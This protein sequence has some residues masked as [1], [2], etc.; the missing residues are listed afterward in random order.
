MKLLHNFSSGFDLAHKSHFGCDHSVRS[1]A[2]FPLTPAL[3]PRERENRLP[4]FGKTNKVG[5]GAKLESVLSEG[6]GDLQLSAVCR[7]ARLRA[8][9][10]IF[11]HA[12]T[13]IRQRM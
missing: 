3:S 9:L 2:S 10:F 1:N 11:A 5:L 8:P 6:E 13:V 12:A 4:V 7:L